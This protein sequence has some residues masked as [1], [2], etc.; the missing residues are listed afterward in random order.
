MSVSFDSSGTTVVI[1]IVD[2][3]DVVVDQT[4]VPFLPR[5]SCSTPL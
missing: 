1:I 2:H 4:V 3:D 5:R